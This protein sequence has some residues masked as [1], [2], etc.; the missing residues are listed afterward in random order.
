MGDFKWQY[1]VPDGTY[2]NKTQS[3]LQGD[4]LLTQSLADIPGTM[5]T[6]TVVIRGL[7]PEGS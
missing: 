6:E 7:S 5:M 4:V 2:K 1:G 3:L